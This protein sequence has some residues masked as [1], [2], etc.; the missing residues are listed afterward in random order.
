MKKAL[1][2]VAVICLS[3]LSLRSETPSAQQCRS[4]QESWRSREA[5]DGI[6]ALPFSEITRRKSEMMDC[7]MNYKETDFLVK[8]SDYDGEI[9]N[10]MFVFIQKHNLV[11]QFRQENGIR[12]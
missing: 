12:N 1:T 6:K 3:C 10:R 7:W 9:I 11:E 8:Q 2:V 5:H 4:D